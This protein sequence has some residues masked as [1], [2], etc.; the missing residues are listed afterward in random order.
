MD[1]SLKIILAVL[2]I[3]IL[4]NLGL[5]FTGGNSNLKVV[6]QDI[7]RS[8]LRLDTALTELNRTR[9]EIDS[10]QRDFLKFNNYIRDIQGRVEIMDL[11]RRVN[12]QRF[13]IKR[14]SIV[15]RLKELY[16]EIEIT[17]E[18]LPP[19]LEYDSRKQ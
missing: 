15:A 16:K 10:L 14:D 5:H 1:R 13:R 19:V 2:A 12:D 7:K 6:L 9:E 4:I 3:L 18:D 11:E 17:G 8:Q